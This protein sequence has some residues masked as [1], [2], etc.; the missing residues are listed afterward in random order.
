M[1]IEMTLDRVTKGVNLTTW[2]FAKT[3]PHIPHFWATRKEWAGSD[4]CSFSHFVGWI[5]THGKLLQWKNT[6]PR[7]YLDLGPWRY[8]H[9]EKLGS[10]AMTVKLVN[11][12]LIAINEAVP[13]NSPASG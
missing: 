2:T 13:W 5:N 4:F 10:D 8:W 7:H 12:Q 6:Q 3:M 11:R 1:G 9:M